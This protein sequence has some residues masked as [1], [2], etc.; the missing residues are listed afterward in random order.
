MQIA[1][2]DPQGISPGLNLGL[3]IL[4]ARL[5]QLDCHVR[6]V[7]LNNYNHAMAQ[8]LKEI[9]AYD[10][11]GISIKS[12]TQNSASQIAKSL[13]RDDIICGGPHISLAGEEF[14]NTDRAFRIGI[15]GEA[16]D[17]LGE[18][19]SGWGKNIDLAAIKGI[20]Y[21][22]L[23]EKETVIIFTGGRALLGDL[24]SLPFPDFSVFDSKNTKIYDYPILTSRGCP[25]AC[26]YCCVGKISGKRIRMRSLEN[27]LAEIDYA[28]SRYQAVDFH[29]LDD[30]F[31]ID[32]NRAKKFC[33]LLIK[34]K[35]RMHWSCPNGIR[36]DCL[37]EELISL[38]K[39]SGLQQVSIGIESLDKEVFQ[40]IKKGE[41]IEDIKK[42]ITLFRKY[43]VKVN[44]F[45]IIGLPLDTYR[46]SLIAMRESAKLRL[47]TALW[48]IFVPYPGTEAW[49][50]INK[51]ARVIRDWKQGFH[52]G[53]HAQ[54]TFETPEFSERQRVA[55]Y[56]LANIRAKNY[57]AFWEQNYSFLRNL[58]SLAIMILRYDPWHLLGHIYYFATNLLS[59]WKY[60]RKQRRR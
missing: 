37:D 32:I 49:E 24:D 15:A 4:A 41:Q 39:L 46:K 14:L 26:I 57:S 28:R 18:L 6:V 45:F 55:I 21:R 11:I 36:A 54:V 43:R 9:R 1:L 16:E 60:F 42:A 33:R 58:L 47:H 44:G 8:R 40:Y 56:R 5:K 52:F 51:E 35:I 31:T 23:S 27:V 22:S 38:M 10:I 59:A 19:V 17:S 3:G 34:N 13:G 30:N 7:D 53:P 48:N 2:I 20:F 12:F 50:K 25:F 29:I